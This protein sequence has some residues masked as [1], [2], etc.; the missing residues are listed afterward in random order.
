MADI[1]IIHGLL[2]PRRMFLFPPSVNPDPSVS[3]HALL[4]VSGLGLHFPLHIRAGRVTGDK[5]TVGTQLRDKCADGS[6]HGLAGKR[7]KVWV[8]SC[9][10]TLACERSQHRAFQLPSMPQSL[11]HRQHQ[12]GHQHH[13]HLSLGSHSKPSPSRTIP[14]SLPGCWY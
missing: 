10:S 1:S 14:P 6:K 11:G 12:A 3:L 7:R 8:L 4:S 9:P 13:Y 5:G 2:A